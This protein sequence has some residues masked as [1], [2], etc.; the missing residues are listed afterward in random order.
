MYRNR[1]LERKIAQYRA[2]F[3]VLLVIGARQVGK[4]TLLA[5]L[6]AKECRQ[7]TFD[8]VTD[9]GN[10]RQDPDFFLD[11]YPPPLLL[12]EIQYAPELLSAI[13]RRVDVDPRPG[14]YLLTGSQNPAL[15]KNVSESL[16]GR[17]MVL[18]LQPLSLA[19]RCGAGATIA[20]PWVEDLFQK[21]AIQLVC[22]RKR[23]PAR[24]LEPTLFSRVWRG[25]FPRLLDLSD[26][27]LADVF[28][29]YV[30]TYIERDIRL[31]A[32]V[33]DQ[34]LFSR[35]LSLCSA[36]TAQEI[37]HSQ[38]GREL[39]VTPQ[40]AHR[41]IALLKATFQW[42]EVPAFHG[43]VIKRISSR[44]KGY[45]SDTGLAAYLQRISSPEA[46]SGHPLQGALF[47]THVVLD[48]RKQ[49]S[50][51]KTPP[52]FYH[53]RSHGGAEVDLLLERD[54]LL[55]PVEIKSGSRVSPSDA[56]GIRSFRQS[57]P[58]LKQGPGLIVAAIGDPFLLPENMVVIPYD[59]A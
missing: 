44:P 17:A 7:F 1:H 26:D 16:A 41:W 11:Q 12:D 9:V 50:L 2:H 32:E 36:L 37:N 40:T 3:P 47:E 39:G 53:W 10:A 35:F 57:H 8:P 21:D 28:S 51:C 29:S 59:L 48:I 56:R 23:L 46:L 22:S 43:N 31:L 6:F 30:R 58:H 27:L 55:V 54:G 49:A 13:K 34:Q 45:L 15:L 24:D 4:T 18:D 52:Q 5:N 38:L 20:T 42:I 14:Q 19:E 25:G 33:Q